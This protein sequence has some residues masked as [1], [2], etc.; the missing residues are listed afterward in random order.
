MK[1]I[2]HLKSI[3]ENLIKEQFINVLVEVRK[4]TKASTFPSTRSEWT[5]RGSGYW[6]SENGCKTE[7]NQQQTQP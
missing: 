6:N 4:L 2:A 3:L 7:V 5:S 1:D